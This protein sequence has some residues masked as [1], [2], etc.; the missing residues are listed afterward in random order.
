MYV[1]FYVI[2]GVGF[3]DSLQKVF[4]REDFCG[5]T[6]KKVYMKRVLWTDFKKGL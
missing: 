2:V 3:V 1:L 4:I 6:S 5:L